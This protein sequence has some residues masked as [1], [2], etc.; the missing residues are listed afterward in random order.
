M[1]REKVA[2]E[3]REKSWEERKLKKREWNRERERGVRNRERG[4]EE[5]EGIANPS[6][7]PCVFSVTRRS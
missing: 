3:K 1:E 7:L 6:H 5:E 4:G 2:S